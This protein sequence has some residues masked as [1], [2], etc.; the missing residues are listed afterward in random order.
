MKY[1]F[2]DFLMELHAKDY[3]GVDDDMPND[4]DNWLEQFDVMDI[5]ELVKKYEVVKEEKFY[6]ELGKSMAEQEGEL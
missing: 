3:H 4:F 6:N 1:T 2:E 5:L